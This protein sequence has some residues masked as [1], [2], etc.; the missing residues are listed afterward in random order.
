MNKL[1]KLFNNFEEIKNIEEIKKKE[2]ID[3][4][5]QIKTKDFLI[6]QVEEKGVPKYLFISEQMYNKIGKENIL[7]RYLNIVLDPFAK[8]DMFYFKW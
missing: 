8:D 1:T 4:L 7:S 2:F 6:K 3:A 5:K